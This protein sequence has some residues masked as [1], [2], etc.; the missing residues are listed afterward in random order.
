ML[1]A[2]HDAICC[3]CHGCSDSLS[4][5]LVSSGY[6]ELLSL[7]NLQGGFHHHCLFACPC[8]LAV[9]QSAC[10]CSHSDREIAVLE[11]MELWASS[12]QLVSL[13]ILQGMGTAIP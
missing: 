1:C 10:L 12:G 5:T 9:C 4:G 6:R 7:W 8:H 13:R 3:F 2:E 11:G